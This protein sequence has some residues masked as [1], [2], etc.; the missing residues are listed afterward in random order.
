MLTHA[1]RAAVEQPRWLDKHTSHYGMM[2]SL[3]VKGSGHGP[4]IASSGK[5]YHARMAR[6]AQHLRCSL[7]ERSERADNKLDKGKLC[8]M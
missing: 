3:R 7:S 1:A 5:L 2:P 4:V 8:K 6:R